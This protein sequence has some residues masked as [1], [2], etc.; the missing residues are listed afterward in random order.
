MTCFPR[1]MFVRA[2]W[3]KTMLGGLLVGCAGV[4][5]HCGGSPSPFSGADAG[6]S[7][8][9]TAGSATP[10]AGAAGSA[11]KSGPSL[12]GEGGSS[13]GNEGGS[14][15]ASTSAG[16][17][18]KN[19]GAGGVEVDGTA[20]A[21]VHAGS[22]GTAVGAEAGRA[23]SAAGGSAG[24]GGLETTAG[25]TGIAGAV[26]VA[27]SAGSG[28][29]GA[30]GNAG[31]P[32]GG[33]GGTGGNS[34]SA[35]TSV[36]GASGSASAGAGGGAGSAGFAG[37]ASGASGAAGSGGSGGSCG[38]SATFRPRAPV[39][40]FMLD[41]SSSMFAPTDYWSPMK[42]SVLATINAYASQIRF[43]LAAYTGVMTQTCPL[44]LTSAGGIALDNS[45]NISQLLSALGAP[46]VKAESPTAAAL[47]SIR[48]TLIAQSGTSKTIFLITDG[49][50][51]FCNDTNASC[52]A[53]AVV[54][55][56]QS[57]FAAGVGTS[58]F[59]IKGSPYLDLTQTQ[60]QANA[61]SGAPAVGDGA[62]TYYACSAD[63]DWHS[64][65][66]AKGS[67][68][69]QPLGTY[70]ATSSTAVPYTL[71]DTAQPEA[72]TTALKAATAALKS[73]TYDLTGAQVNLALASQGNVR[74]DGVSVP[75]DVSNGWHMKNSTELELVG[76]A[77]ANWRSSAAQAISFDFACSMLNP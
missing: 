30:T 3:R 50:H 74:I 48:P 77:C 5:L 36:G 21:S 67:P 26:N 25:A 1:P 16:S 19:A 42:A 44:E 41:R 4:T 70:V 40:F 54:A 58:V 63:P 17:G 37:S 7:N 66:V 57:I 34:G 27:G 6:S 18:G 33:S 60:A 72:M 11:G 20:G 56:L 68:T 49:G 73:C 12:A 69:T 47:A 59:G 71:L 62:A 43:G 9:G 46:G 28:D 38:N 14:S 75:M 64:L 76:S 61:G 29:S 65:W 53:D 24:T 13:S 10:I 2:I 39:V 8:S 22:G 45:A 31:A 52:P 55:E 23:G 35:G 32:A 15:G 51:D